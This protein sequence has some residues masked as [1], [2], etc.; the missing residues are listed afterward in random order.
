MRLPV[1]IAADGAEGVI[2]NPVTVMDQDAAR[3]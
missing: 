2:I 1:L 3:A